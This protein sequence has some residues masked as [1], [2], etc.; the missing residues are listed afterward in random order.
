M[1][2]LGDYLGEDDPVGKSFITKKSY[3]K[4]LEETFIDDL[5]S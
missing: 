1:D 2:L 4:L 5:D 3:Y